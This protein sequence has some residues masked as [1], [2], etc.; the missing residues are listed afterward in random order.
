M[1]WNISFPVEL[2][3]AGNRFWGGAGGRVGIVH[4]AIVVISAAALC[5]G[6]LLVDR[7][8][9]R[10]AVRKQS[11]LGLFSELCAAHQLDRTERNVL[12]SAA[13]TLPESECCRV[14]IDGAI[15]AGLSASNSPD[16]AEFAW[17]TKK[18]FGFRP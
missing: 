15:L 12:W 18:L 14:F 7:I 1:L 16:A 3:A 8:R 11:P 10:Y 13:E 9:T 6:V 4:V 2:F 17:L 5:G